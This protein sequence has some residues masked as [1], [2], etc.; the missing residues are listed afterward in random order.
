MR[1]P[2]PSSDPEH[3]S[4]QV[5]S[6]VQTL[7]SGQRP[8]NPVLSKQSTRRLI[9][10]AV[11]EEIKIF[12][13]YKE[14][15]GRKA[16]E[17]SV[18]LNNMSTAGRE[19]NDDSG[20]R[21]SKSEESR[22][23]GASEKSRSDSHE[24]YR[25]HQRGRQQ[26]RQDIEN[27]VSGTTNHS[28]PDQRFHITEGAGPPDVTIL[29]SR[30]P[31]PQPSHS[32]S[33]SK[34][35]EKGGSHHKQ[36]FDSRGNPLVWS[37]SKQGWRDVPVGPPPTYKFKLGPT[38]GLGTHVKEKFQWGVE[39]YE[40]EQRK[41]E[42]R[43]RGSLEERRKKR[44]EEKEQG[45][46]KEKRENHTGKSENQ[47]REPEVRHQDNE[48]RSQ[49]SLRSPARHEATPDTDRR[50]RRESTQH[51][52]PGLSPEPRSPCRSP[53]PHS[54]HS[55]R[56]SPNSEEKARAISDAKC[57]GERLARREARSRD[58]STTHV[59]EAARAQLSNTTRNLS[60]RDSTSPERERSVHQDTDPSYPV[61]EEN[62]HSRQ[63][64][65]REQE[66]VEREQGR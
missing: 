6:R 27:L 13:L 44:R 37:T 30:T 56:R 66:Q 19:R 40:L 16:R 32:S 3:Y 29:L 11:V 39:G 2:S 9:L 59:E 33:H 45:G 46:G 15:K 21:R 7:I 24:R 12:R 38:I 52:S 48:R 43:A 10:E 42:R 23:G 62:A 60:R 22:R 57:R 17:N 5:Q 18:Q 41:K 26:E 35:P 54:L 28:D 64:E 58:A 1:P 53:S 20:R 4:Q 61:Y 8:H 31:S 34:H 50:A 25:G 47:S 36:R 14:E 63:V 65:H 55:S 51:H 49:R